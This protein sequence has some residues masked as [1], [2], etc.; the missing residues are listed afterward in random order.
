MTEM[1]VISQPLSRNIELERRSVPLDKYDGISNSKLSLLFCFGLAALYLGLFVFYDKLHFPMI[2]DENHFWRTTLLFSKSLVP[3]FR[4]LR[5]YNELNTP[6]PFIIFGALAHQF[7]DGLFAGRFLNLI[8]SLI[9]ICTIGLP[10]GRKDARSILA[11]MS[12]LSV[13]YYLWLSTHLYT[14]I[15]SAF[16]VLAGFW[17]YVRNKHILSSIPFI[18][19]IACRQ[20]M[21]VFPLAIAA[22]EFISYLRRTF[23]TGSLKRASIGMPRIY[24]PCIA[25]SMAAL[26][27][28]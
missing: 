7:K 25:P 22:H 11:A 2:W 10:L 12:I 23:E 8:V 16:F 9:I 21:V 6:L 14:D 26:T 13:P 27:L 4:V 18:L 15:L 24:A 17:L 1:Q 19:A 28:L 3:D 5:N 20:Y